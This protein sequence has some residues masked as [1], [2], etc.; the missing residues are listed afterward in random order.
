MYKKGFV[1]AGVAANRYLQNNNS[2]S[3]KPGGVF[4]SLCGG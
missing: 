2:Y 4:K 1:T 3:I